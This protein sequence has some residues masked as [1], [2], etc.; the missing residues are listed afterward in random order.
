[1]WRF[2]SGSGVRQADLLTQ[3]S[4]SLGNVESAARLTLVVRYGTDLR[5]SVIAASQLSGRVSNPMAI[6][7]GWNVYLGVGAD[8]VHNQIFI[9]GSR[10]R[11]VPRTELKHEQYWLLDRKST[12]LNSSHV[13]ISYAVFCSRKKNNQK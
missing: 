11:S 13:A 2:A 5:R 9:S 4:G 7:R 3:I 1:M 10:L 8:Y 6:D 12:R